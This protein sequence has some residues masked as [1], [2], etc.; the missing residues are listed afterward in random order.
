MPLCLRMGVIL[1]WE[2]RV[3]AL[4][5]GSTVLAC[6]Y[7][8]AKKVFMGRDSARV[9]NITLLVSRIRVSQRRLLDVCR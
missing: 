4:S 9:L 7:Y 1:R 3:G 2:R 5:L 6:T 8:I